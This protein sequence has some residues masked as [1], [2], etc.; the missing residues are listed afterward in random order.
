[1]MTKLVGAL[2]VPLALSLSQVGCHLGPMRAR[3]TPARPVESGWLLVPDVPLVTQRER[4][5]C[6]AAALTMVLRF[7]QPAT[8]N[9]R[10]RAAVGELDDKK[11]IAAGR[12]RAIAREMG[13]QAFLIQGTFDDLVNEVGRGR[14]V[15]VGT[16]QVKRGRGYPHYE[17]VVGVN[18]RER[19]ILAADPAQGW[20]E[21]SLDA[22]E[23]RWKP[24]KRLA[25]VVFAPEDG[26][27]SMTAWMTPSPSTLATVAPPGRPMAAGPA[28]SSAPGSPAPSR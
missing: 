11:G 3:V 19:K 26:P 25:L 14:P 13:M 27:G 7:W 1:M 23:A 9:E 8:S 20:R 18:Q 28:V 12:L 6:G 5:D 16:V 22:F 21:Q 15:L 17:V 10:V 4:A 24:S 2:I